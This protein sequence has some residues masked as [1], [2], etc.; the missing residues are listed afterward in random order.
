MNSTTSTLSADSTLA[1]AA[2]AW[3]HPLQRVLKWTPHSMALVG[4]GA[5]AGAALLATSSHLQQDLGERLDQLLASNN[6]IAPAISHIGMPAEAAATPDLAVAET[7]SATPADNNPAGMPV[8]NPQDLPSRQ[9]AVTYWI[10]KKYRVAP[11]AVGMLVKEAYAVGKIEKIDP[12]LIL[13]I[14][15]VESSF[16]PFAQSHVGAQ[17]LMQVMTHIHS[18]KYEDHGGSFAALN[19]VSNLHVGVQVLKETIA[20]AGSVRGG[21]KHYVGAANL[22]DDQGYGS[23]VLA[24]FARIRAVAQG[25]Q[26]AHN[27]QLPHGLPE[28]ASV[29]K[30]ENKP[31]APEVQ[32]AK[33]EVQQR[34][35]AQPLA[36]ASSAMNARPVRVSTRITPPAK[37]ESDLAHNDSIRAEQH[38]RNTL[39]PQAA[40]HDK[41]HAVSVASGVHM[42]A[43]E[44]PVA[45]AGNSSIQ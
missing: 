7:A 38:I 20:R 4:V 23:K 29:A 18:D 39:T 32:L 36:S 44:Q 11:E 31:A 43:Q 33:A 30:R 12:A 42:V 15:A 14:M 19:P 6:P 10:A 40:P 27:A 28:A 35:S 37:Q 24:E 45:D 3:K 9:A 34:G 16:N 26:V 25:Q 8:V 1:T 2:P 5:I 13:A 22:P 21:L 17:G 41:Q